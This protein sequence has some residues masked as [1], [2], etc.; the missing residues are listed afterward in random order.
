[1]RDPARTPDEARRFFERFFRPARF[2]DD[3]PGFLTGYYEPELPASRMRSPAFPVPLYRAPPDLVRLPPS[4]PLPEGLDDAQ[5]FARLDA[6]GRLV[7]Y[8]DRAAIE[9]GWLSAQGLELV[10]LADPVD[11][12]FVHVQ[13]SA[14]LRLRTAPP[15]ASATPPRTGTASRRSAAC[16]WRRANCRWKRPI[17]PASAAGS[18]R[19]RSARRP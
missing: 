13:G 2:A 18:P 6:S 3:A 5:G 19:T 15:C 4:E 9:D 11:A 10:W 1:M 8:P 7:P 16:W 17:W 12:F 14:R